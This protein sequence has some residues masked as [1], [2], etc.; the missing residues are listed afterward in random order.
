MLVIALESGAN[1]LIEVVLQYLRCVC[2]LVLHF[3]LANLLHQ[4][5]VA[6]V[7]E[8]I[9]LIS[10]A[11]SHTVVLRLEVAYR[12]VDRSLGSLVDGAVVQHIL[13]TLLLGEELVSLQYGIQSATL[14]E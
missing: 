5:L 9:G 10:L 8:H 12:Q 7:F 6:Y 4:G 1:L 2:Q 11:V 13:R 3:A 14:G